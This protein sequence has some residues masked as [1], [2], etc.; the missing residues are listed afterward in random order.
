[1]GFPEEGILGI[2]LTIFTRRSTQHFSPSR[3]HVG[4][5]WVTLRKLPIVYAVDYASFCN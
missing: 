2:H 4:Q 1:M 5:T 3:P